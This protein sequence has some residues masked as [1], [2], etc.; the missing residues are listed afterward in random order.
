[1][2]KKINKRN[3][4]QLLDATFGGTFLYYQSPYWALL[5]RSRHVYTINKVRLD[6]Q[7]ISPNI[8]SINWLF[9]KK[10]TVL[11]ISSPRTNLKAREKSPVKE[12]VKQDCLEH[13]LSE[14]ALNTLADLSLKRTFL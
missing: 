10:I 5:L 3:S 8:V 6:G 13:I 11:I 4:K 12:K 14:I 2:E 1:M 7:I 9:S